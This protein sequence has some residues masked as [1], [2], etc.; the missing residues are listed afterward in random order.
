MKERL[1]TS[2][3]LVAF[4]LAVGFINNIFLTN[5]VIALITIAG[6]YEAKK[7]LK[8]EDERVFYFLAIL[9]ILAIFINPL[10]IGVVGV[11]A[12]AGYVAY[13]QKEM[14]LIS[15]SFY[16]F[17]PMMLLEALYLKGDMKAIFWLIVIIALTDSMAYVIGKNFGG[18]FIN[19]KFSPTS[20]NKTYEG[21]IGGI[22]SGSI[23]GAFVGL[24]FFD[25][26]TSFV[27]SLSV[28]IA[29]VFGDLFESFLKRRAG[30]KDS[31]NILPGHGGILDRIDGY[32]F[33]AP[34]MWSIIIA[35]GNI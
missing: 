17:L 9:S 12:I 4:L 3:V 33:G 27:I 29:S 34:L 25:F 15:I 7:L 19:A 20:P 18:K 35:L 23:I 11:L 32:L 13:Y 1:I 21:V 26:L 10:L 22:L 8:I 24:M 2:I 31:G 28:S 6:M 14:N 5:L 30:V 16:P